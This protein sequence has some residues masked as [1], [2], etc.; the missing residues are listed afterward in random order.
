M[1][2]RALFLAIFLSFWGMHCGA[3][4]HTSHDAEQSHNESPIET[5]HGNEQFSDKGGDDTTAT[6][7]KSMPAHDPSQSTLLALTTQELELQLQLLKEKDPSR[8]AEL[9]TKL[10][11]LQAKRQTFYAP[12]NEE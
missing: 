2:H 3:P 6:S 12:Q 4:N 11:S 9:E 10:K 8:R 1:N 7:S 5:P